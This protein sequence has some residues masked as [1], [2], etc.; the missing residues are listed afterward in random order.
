[1]TP[2]FNAT[3]ATEAP[4]SSVSSTTRRRS[5]ALRRRRGPAPDNRVEQPD[6]ILL[7]RGA[8]RT[9][10]TMHTFSRKAYMFFLEGGIRNLPPYLRPVP[11]SLL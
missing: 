3:R 9:N 7:F 11:V 6:Q 10:L 2:Y 5:A 8:I 4:A 1:L